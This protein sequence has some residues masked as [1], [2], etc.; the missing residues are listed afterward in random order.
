MT[1]SEQQNDIKFSLSKIYVAKA[2]NHP[3]GVF[4]KTD[5]EENETIEIFPITPMQFRTEYQFDKGVLNYVY[6][7]D[8]CECKECSKHG[9]VMFLPMGYGGIYNFTNETESNAKIVMFYESFFA[10][11]I[12]TKKIEKDEEVLTNFADTYFYRQM[13]KSQNEN[14][15]I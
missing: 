7:N 9:H 3:R 5:I 10:K 14:K 2:K 6:V 12:A 1:N 11:V 4:A 13:L 8:S 15:E